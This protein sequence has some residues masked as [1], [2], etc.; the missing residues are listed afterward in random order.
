MLGAEPNRGRIIATSFLLFCAGIF[1]TAYTARRPDSGN[2]LATLTAELLRPVQS[3]NASLQS[4]VSQYWHNYIALTEAQ[5]ENDLLRAELIRREGNMTMA[6]ALASENFRLKR[7]LGMSRKR[8]SASVAARV[9][10][11]DPSAWKQMLTIDQGSRAGI[12]KNSAVI[13]VGGRVVGQVVRVGPSTA[14]VLLVTDQ[15]SGVDALIESSRVRGVASG[16]A[17]GGLGLS[18]N[19]PTSF[20]LL[21]VAHD[22]LVSVGERVVTS[23]MDGIFPAGLLIGRVSKVGS[24]ASG[25]AQ[26]IELKPAVDF[27]R[28]EWVLVSPAQ[29]SIL[30]PEV[31]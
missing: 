27:E 18:G 28:I 3:L 8:F 24:Q 29:H 20:G 30:S 15:A 31:P 26:S 9:I 12:E 16:L 2:L 17:S 23:G 4:S 11:Y 14:R 7:L 22:Q 5:Q 10:G 1:L 21:F 6:Q 13:A 19:G 25:A